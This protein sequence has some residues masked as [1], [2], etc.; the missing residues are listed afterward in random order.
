VRPAAKYQLASCS[1]FA[2][3]LL[4]ADVLHTGH[5]FWKFFKRET[6]ADSR[7]SAVEERLKRSDSE[8]ASGNLGGMSKPPSPGASQGKQPSYDPYNSGAFD[9]HGAWSKV[10]RKK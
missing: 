4:W 10:T 7:K 6:T 9:K 8:T 1:C 5:M 2:S 3:G